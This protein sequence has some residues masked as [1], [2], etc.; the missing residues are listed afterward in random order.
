MS[1]APRQLQWFDDLSAQSA[2]AAACVA[3]HGA[4]GLQSVLSIED[5]RHV[6]SAIDALLAEALAEVAEN[7]DAFRTHFGL[8][9]ERERRCDV[10]LPLTNDVLRNAL[11]K[12]V[13]RTLPVL[14]DL[15]TD[16]G[17]IK[18]LSCVV[19]DPG[20]KAQ[21]WHPDDPPLQG[22][23]PLY[24]LFVALQ[25]VTEDLG[26]TELLLG[27]HNQRANNALRGGNAQRIVDAGTVQSV[28]AICA[29]P[30]DAYVMD[31]RLWH[32]GGANNATGTGRRR[33]LSISVQAPGNSILRGESTSIRDELVN[34]LKLKHYRRW[35]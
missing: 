16:D 33:V 29:M 27:T 4:C 34:R 32:R 24:T 31:S 2:A 6:A 14:S 23:T 21:P 15:V 3:E 19:S 30:G 12:I 35:C 9:Q 20:A 25:T 28:S 18:E 26:P 11:Q 8:I 7:E 1:A 22:G 17:M 5:A 10:K 13:E